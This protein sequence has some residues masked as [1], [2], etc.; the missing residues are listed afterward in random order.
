MASVQ[1]RNYLKSEQTRSYRRRID[2]V[3]PDI[4]DN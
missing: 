4:C 2:H 3:A 1:R